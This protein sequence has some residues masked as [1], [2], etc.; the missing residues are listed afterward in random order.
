MKHR[1]SLV[2][3]L[4]VLLITASAFL[5]GYNVAEDRYAGETSDEVVS[6]V[7]QVSND[8]KSI[9]ADA[10]Q[11]VIPDYLL[12]PEMEMPTVEKDGV[13]Y[14]GVI[15]IPAQGIQLGVG[16]GLTMPVL[17]KVPCR[18]SGSIYDNTC[19]IAGHNYKSHF[20]NLA[21]T[22]VGDTVTFTDVDGVVFS[23]EVSEIE[24][25][26]GKDVDGM[27]A[28]E[29]D[30]TLFTCQLNRAKRLAIRCMRTDRGEV[31]I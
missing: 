26:D 30:L 18:Y 29:W 2:I 6:L 16:S 20:G 17:K 21:G 12:N 3:S 24:T 27:K 1:S 31:S 5:T 19:I 4:G 28:G 25:I 9:W 22:Q 8:R 7:T 23:Y 15:E 10:D 14:I 13:D 11:E